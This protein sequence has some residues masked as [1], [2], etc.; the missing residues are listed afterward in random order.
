M[1]GR[2]G[3]PTAGSTGGVMSTEKTIQLALL[4]GAMS[5]LIGCENATLSTAQSPDRLSILRKA[6]ASDLNP[7][8]ARDALLAARLTN[9]LQ[10]DPETKD[11][12]IFVSVSQGRARLSGFVDQAVTKFRAGAVAAETAGIA[13]VENRLILR[14]RAKDDPIG[15]ARVYL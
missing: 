1:T 10:K 15:N 12:K 8:I 4:A 11:L 6:Y 7:D 5:L 14:H 2:A 3:R 9:R 13:S